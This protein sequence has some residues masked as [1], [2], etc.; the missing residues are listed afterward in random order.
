M[1]IGVLGTGF[2]AYHVSIYKKLSGVD[3]LKIFGRN[4]EKLRQLRS[5][6]EI[7]V[8]N[9]INDIINCKDIELVDICLPISLHKEYAIEALKNGKHVFCETPLALSVEDA[10]E[11]KKVADTYNRRVFVNM[12]IKFQFPY[13]YVYNTCQDYNLGKIKA[14]H[15]KRKTPPFWGDLSLNK[16]SPDLMIHDIDFVSWLLG[17]PK[18]INTAGVNSKQGESHVSALLHYDG[19]VVEVQASSM[20]PKSYQFFVAFEAI[21]ENG[22]IEFIGREREDVLKLFTDEGQ[23]T[24]EISNKNCYESS[25]QHVIDCCSKNEPTILGIEDA[26][27]SLKTALEIRDTVSRSI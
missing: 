25:L 23:K 27:I 2:G 26:I 19:T 7:D 24:L 13:E 8:T 20:M 10:I 16:I 5:D 1:K 4:E 22:T 3:Y 12:F 21:F 18:S 17:A 15:I 14:L 9:N 6:L 11:I